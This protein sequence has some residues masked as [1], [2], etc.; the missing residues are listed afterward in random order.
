MVSGEVDE[1][2]AKQ[3]HNLWY[4]E[5]KGIAPPDKS[6]AAPDVSGATPTT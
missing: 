4:D 1:A 2:F 3:H 6:S 5:V